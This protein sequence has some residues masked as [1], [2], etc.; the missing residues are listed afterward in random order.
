MSPRNLESIV[1]R[2]VQLWEMRQEHPVDAS[3]GIA[4][5]SAKAGQVGGP[6]LGGEKNPIRHPWLHYWGDAIVA[7]LTRLNQ[8]D[9]H[10]EA[11]LNDGM[12][13]RA[14]DQTEPGRDTS[15]RRPRPSS[16]RI[17]PKRIANRT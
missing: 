15:Q 17:G 9:E 16:K 5:K 2:Q 13:E 8:I 7:E 4:A 12:N 11:F 1:S 6:G 14:N 3:S 10:A